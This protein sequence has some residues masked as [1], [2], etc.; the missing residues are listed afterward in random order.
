[1][2][3]SEAKS[4]LRDDL[5][6]ETTVSINQASL[7]H[8]PSSSSCP[9]HLFFSLDYFWCSPG[10]HQPF[11]RT[12]SSRRNLLLVQPRCHPAA[13]SPAWAEVP[14]LSFILS[15]PTLDE[16]NF[17]IFTARA[18]PPAPSQPLVEHATCQSHAEQ[19]LC[20]SGEPCSAAL[21]LGL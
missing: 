4:H 20:Y 15:S 3:F 13:I 11:W 19:C 16:V 14:Q 2:S 18:A 17:D 12:C 7:K 6:L 5:S 8:L 9:E 1:M 10:K 21:L